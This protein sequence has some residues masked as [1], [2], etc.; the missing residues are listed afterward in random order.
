MF[1][2]V[3]NKTTTEN[4]ALQ[5]YIKYVFLKH[6]KSYILRAYKIGYVSFLADSLTSKN[7]INYL[8]NLSVCRKK[9]KISGW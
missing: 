6:F 9:I 3:T 2:N 4:Q 8:I 5:Q 1:Y 7:S